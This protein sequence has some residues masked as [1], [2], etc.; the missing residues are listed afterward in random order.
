LIGL[1]KIR[2]VL[3]KSQQ[4]KRAIAAFD[5]AGYNYMDWA[6]AAAQK[7]D[8]PI[9]LMFYPNFRKYISFE[10]FAGIKEILAKKYSIP[11]IA[12]L[13][14]SKDLD[15]I[16]AAIDAGFDSV[17]VDASTLSFE[18]NVAMTQKVVAIAHPA[19]V[20][21]E[22]ELGKVGSGSVAS[23]FKDSS[24]YTNPEEAKA[25]V[26]QTGVDLLAVAIGNS[27]GVYVETPHLDIPRLKELKAA[28]G[29]PLVLHGTSLIPE[30]QVAEAV[31]NGICKV[32]IATELYM[33]ATKA[34]DEVIAEEGHR[35][36][37]LFYGE[38]QVR[39]RVMQYLDAKIRLLGRYE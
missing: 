2:E 11:V 3:A 10:E 30:D 38:T 34:L 28:A 9:F 7:Y 27:H 15:E 31:E 25:F 12:H 21:V 18:E 26:E 20:S 17:M 4:E 5:T 24:L 36:D 14:H 13:D 1:E 32:N 8:A 33:A 29:I 16:K 19:N 35:K 6:A 39:P 37:S 22:A 23:D